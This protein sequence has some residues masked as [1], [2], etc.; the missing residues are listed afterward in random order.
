MSRYHSEIVQLYATAL[1]DHAVKNDIL[2]RLSKE[3][4]TLLPILHNSPEMIESISAPIYLKHQQNSLI[5]KISKNL[6]LPKELINLLYLLAQNQK[7]ELVK[8]ILEVFQ[9]LFIEQSGKKIV[10]VI[11]SKQL[12]QEERIKLKDSLE[13]ILSAK[14]ILNYK[15][16][17]KILGGIIIRLDDKMMDASLATELNHLNKNVRKKIALI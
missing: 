1:F 15:I 17:P 2:D 4:D 9:E 6:E 7:L 13:Q 16:D 5:A 11:L 10:T 14:I 8:D 12:E 3:I